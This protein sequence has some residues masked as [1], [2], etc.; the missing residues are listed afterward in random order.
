[1]L[2]SRVSLVGAHSSHLRMQYPH[3]TNIHLTRQ[4]NAQD[5]NISVI[6]RQYLGIT[7]MPAT[8]HHKPYFMETS[9]Q[10]VNGQQWFDIT[11]ES[12][13]AGHGMFLHPHLTTSTLMIASKHSSP[14]ENEMKPSAARLY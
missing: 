14:E 5:A 13:P 2:Y 4:F 6:K 9:Q 7:N 1:M 12:D 10:R 8:R 11:D 3:I